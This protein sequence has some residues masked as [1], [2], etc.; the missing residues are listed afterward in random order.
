MHRHILAVPA[1]LAAVMLAA[2]CATTTAPTTTVRATAGPATAAAHAAAAPRPSCTQQYTA[3]QHGPAR[4]TG[5]KLGNALTAVQDASGNSDLPA[6]TSALE[7]AGADAAAARP[8]PMPACA[9]PA[10]YWGQ[11]LAHIRAAGDNA[12][13]ASGLSALILA[14]VPLKAV[15]GLEAKLGAELKRTVPGAKT[16]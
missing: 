13:T 16:G 9:D 1:A 8:Y 14:E 3:W 10:G 15:P 12:G 5:K 6:L 2:G 11:M 7:T 4:A